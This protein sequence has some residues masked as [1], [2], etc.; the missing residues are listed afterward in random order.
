MDSETEKATA[1]DAERDDQP[2]DAPNPGRI[3]GVLI[4][5]SVFGL[6]LGGLTLAGLHSLYR[7]TWQGY[8]LSAARADAWKGPTLLIASA[9]V[10]LVIHVL[11]ARL[12]ARRIADWLLIGYALPLV[13]AAG[14]MVSQEVLLIL[15]SRV[16]QEL[17][18]KTSAL[19]PLRSDLA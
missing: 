5:S 7:T 3:D 2:Q 1:A 19:M 10:I 17:G 6:V 16:P 13:L 18:V 14:L 4:G 9:V 12:G 15:R 11:L 8:L